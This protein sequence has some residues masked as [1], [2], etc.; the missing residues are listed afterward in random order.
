[1][2]LSIGVVHNC[3]LVV[4]CE[5]GCGRAEKHSTVQISDG[6]WNP[7]CDLLNIKLVC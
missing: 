2:I 6:D 5:N 4:M 7:I 3:N 1:M